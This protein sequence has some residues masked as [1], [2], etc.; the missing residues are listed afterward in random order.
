MALLSKAEGNFKLALKGAF[1]IGSLQKMTVISDLL[2]F[3]MFISSVD[4]EY[5]LS[6]YAKFTSP[7]IE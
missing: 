6:P 4:T 7:L 1:Y 2:H 3:S 5:E